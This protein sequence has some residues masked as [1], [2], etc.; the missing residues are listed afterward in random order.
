MTDAGSDPIIRDLRERISDNDRAIVEAINRRLELVARLKAYKE[1]RGVQ[2][3]DPAREDW[4]LR[5]L[6]RANRGPLSSEGLQEIYAELLDLTKR[7]VARAEQ[8]AKT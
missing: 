2:F 8:V 3:V 5:Y 7:E 1:S 6:A 4:L